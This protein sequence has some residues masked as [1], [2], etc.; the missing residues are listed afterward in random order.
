MSATAADVWIA[1]HD[2]GDLVRADAIVLIRFDG[3][4]RLTAQ[5]RDEARVTVA[6]LEGSASGRPP[7]D[8][9]CQLIRMISELAASSGAHLVYAHKDDRGWRWVSE[10]L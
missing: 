8:F 1:A 4:G 3:T 10:T 7:G 5:L 9:H 6:L 2:G